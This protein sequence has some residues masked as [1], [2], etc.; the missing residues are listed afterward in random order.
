MTFKN[1]AFVFLGIALVILAGCRT[2]PVY[3]VSDQVVTT[4]IETH[5]EDDVR[6]AIVRAGSGLGWQMKEESAGHIIATLHLRTHMAKVDINYNKDKYNITYKDSVDLSYDGTIIH[7]NY[8]G[9][10]QNLDR[11]IKVQL[12]TL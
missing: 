9:W 3:N 10:V 8:N 7:S 6:K 11:A 5:T 12:N 1:V 4:N 2:A